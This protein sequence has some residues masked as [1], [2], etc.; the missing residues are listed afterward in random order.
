M[1]WFLALLTKETS[2]L[3]GLIFLFKYPLK[4][5]WRYLIIMLVVAFY[6]I[7]IDLILEPEQFEKTSQYFQRSRFNFWQKNFADWNITVSHH[8]H[9]IPNCRDPNSLGQKVYKLEGIVC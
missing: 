7:A 2:I 6:F 4:Q 5:W 1:C 9:F 3:F 8:I